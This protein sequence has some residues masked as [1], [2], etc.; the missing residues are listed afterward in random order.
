MSIPSDSNEI[1]GQTPDTNQPSEQF[2]DQTAQQSPGQTPKRLPPEAQGKPAGETPASPATAPLAESSDTPA[3]D[4]PATAGAHWP[5]VHPDL[6]ANLASAERMAAKRAQDPSPVAEASSPAPDEESEF[7]VPPS[8]VAEASSPDAE[9]EFSVP[10]SPAWDAPLPSEAEKADGEALPVY[11]FDEATDGIMKTSDQNSGEEEEEEDGEEEEEED[12]ED[13][14]DRP[15]TLRDHLVELRKRIFRAFLWI[16]AGFVGCFPFASTLFG[17]LQAPLVAVMP[18]GS[19]FI[20]TGLPEGFF[21]EMKVAFVAG[22]FIT[23][24]MVFYQ[25]WCFIAPGLYREEKIYIIPLALFSAICFIGGAS[26]CFFVAFP[27]AFEF[28]MSYSTETIKAMPSISEYLHLVLQMLLAFGLVFELP[29]FVLFLS[30]LG[31]VTAAQL[32]RFRRYAVL[33]NVILAAVL[34]PPDVFSQLLMAGPLLLLYEISILIA[35]IF[36][37]KPKDKDAEEGDPASAPE[38]VPAVAGAAPAGERATEN[39]QG[40]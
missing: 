32:R 34:T 9:S 31:M 3:E 5:A 2:S 18:A 26:F 14:E 19:T 17:Y 11:E 10:P 29:L 27:F 25:I 7:T 36:G 21:I 16:L 28:F 22:L 33:V 1:P 40:D 38:G 30:R 39:R 12:G 20:F 4:P 35:V 15:L 6:L 24:P 37:K 13:E 8:P 23:S